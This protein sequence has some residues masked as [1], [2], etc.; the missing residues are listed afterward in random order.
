MCNDL[1]EGSRCCAAYSVVGAIFTFWVG[2]MV[3]TQAF[4]IPGI[5]DPEK[6]QANAYGAFGMFVFTFIVSSLGV[7]YDS[8]NKV[9]EVETEGEYQLGSDNVPNYGA[10]N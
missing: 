3:S 7:W 9:E 6:A 4:F 5:D 8:Q 1:G 2:V 10:A